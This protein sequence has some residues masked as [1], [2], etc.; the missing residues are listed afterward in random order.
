MKQNW[1]GNTTQK[2]APRSRAQLRL[3]AFRILA[4][5]DRGPTYYA[6]DSKLYSFDHHDKHG[7]TLN[8]AP[9]Y[10]WACWDSARRSTNSP[11]PPIQ[12]RCARWRTAWSVDGPANTSWNGRAWRTSSQ[13]GRANDARDDASWWTTWNLRRRCECS[14][15]GPLNATSKPDV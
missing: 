11:R 14:C 12:S 6:R 13:P 15:N 10:A 8:H 4:R 1:R 2:S 9:W 3:S 7:S 5:P